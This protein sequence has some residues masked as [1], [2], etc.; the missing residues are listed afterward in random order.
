MKHLLLLSLIL[1]ASSE[2]RNKYEYQSGNSYNTSTF[3]DTTTVRG[4]NANTG[5]SWSGQYRSDGSSNGIDSNGNMWNESA[6]GSY[7][8]TDG[9]ICYGK[10]ANRVCN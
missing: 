5:S 4:Y 1:V 7:Y 6:S 3:G 2:A 9:T 10:G 8:S